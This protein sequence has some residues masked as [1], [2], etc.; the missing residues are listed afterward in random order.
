MVVEGSELVAL[1]LV[2]FI[3]ELNPMQTESVKEA[4]HHIHRHKHTDR[5]GHP[6]KVTDEDSEVCASD[7]MCLETWNDGVLDEHSG[8]LSVGK[9]EG[10]QSEV[11]CRVGNGS[12]HKLNGLNQL[13]DKDVGESV[14]V[15]TVCLGLVP[16]HILNLVLVDGSARVSA[17]ELLVSPVLLSMDV[18]VFDLGELSLLVRGRSRGE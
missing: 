11:G 1:A 13:M 9:R 14:A 7:S 17:L 18:S 4:L 5:E 2:E 3:L 8:K 16:Q 15:A 6:H 12:Q 10:P